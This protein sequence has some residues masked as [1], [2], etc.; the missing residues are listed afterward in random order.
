MGV[1]VGGWRVC[2]RGGRGGGEIERRK[3]E[4][5]C[6]VLISFLLF[7]LLLLGNLRKNEES[8]KSAVET[9]QQALRKAEE[10]REI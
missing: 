3:R 4:R 5:A 8:L 9:A 7:L 1:Y 10:V 6:C 2:V